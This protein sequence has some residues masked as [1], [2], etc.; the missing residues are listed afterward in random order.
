M[1]KRTHMVLAIAMLA[2]ACSRDQPNE[3][4]R[5]PK[6]SNPPGDSAKDIHIDVVVAGQAKAPITAAL[7]NATKPDWADARRKAWRFSTLLTAAG[8]A[9]DAA[10]NNSSVAVTGTKGVTVQFPATASDAAMVPVIVY[11]QRGEIVAQFVDPKDPFPAFHG[12]G[13]HLGRSP[14]PMPRVADVSKIEIAVP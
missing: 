3:G 5:L 2:F 6:L 12:E 8:A 9:N 14:N 13:G 4:K 11:S 10:T 7:L 1:G